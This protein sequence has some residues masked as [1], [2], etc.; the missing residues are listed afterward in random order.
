MGRLTRPVLTAERLRLE[1]L[2]IA[3]AAHV[4]ALDA[5]P[6]VM[7]HITG[8]ALTADE[9]RRELPTL[10]RDLAG[11]GCWVGFLADDFVGV[12]CVTRDA[13]H[14]DWG[15]L[16]FRL[17]PPAWGRGLAAEGSQALLRHAFLTVGL[18]RVRAETLAV[19]TRARSV[20]ERLG[21]GQESVQAE[22]GT[23]VAAGREQGDVVY[24]I[25]AAT[26]SAGQGGATSTAYWDAVAADF[27]EAADHGLRAPET[28]SAW[29]RVLREVLPHAPA[30]IADLGCGTGS[31]TLLMAGEGYLVDGVDL[32]PAMI[33]QARTKAGAHPAVR[34]VVGD[35]SRPPLRPAAYDVV[36]TRHVL[37]ALPDPEGALRAWGRL[38]VDGGRLVLTE[39]RW[40]TGAGLTAA[41]TVSLLA[42]AGLRGVVHP[43]RDPDLWGGETSDERY[44]V[45]CV[46][47]R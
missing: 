38:L 20:L 22:E 46:L 35:V 28:R 43:L 41:Q 10:T 32:S 26:W 12:W 2:G 6:E 8:H 24:A 34:L 5:D 30:R 42:Q 11:L 13:E 7:R 17:A 37:W 23:E 9:S 15:E 14:P 47:H 39:G 31:M 27:D 25:D 16:T 3:H 40:S 29:R 18:D 19:H 1:P 4:V 36:F 21:M 33:R 45:V 44:V